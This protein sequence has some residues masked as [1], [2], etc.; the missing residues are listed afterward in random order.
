MLLTKVKGQEQAKNFCMGTSLDQSL[1]ILTRNHKFEPC[2]GKM[3]WQAEFSIGAVKSWTTKNIPAV[4]DTHRL[5]Y[6]GK[7]AQKS[8]VQLDEL[9]QGLAEIDGLRFLTSVELGEAMTQKGRYT[10]AITGEKEQLTPMFKPLGRQIR[11][12]I[13]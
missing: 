6:V 13:H 8:L 1:T 7:H 5:N 3:E 11:K 12:W 2:R 10:N 9:L 4:L